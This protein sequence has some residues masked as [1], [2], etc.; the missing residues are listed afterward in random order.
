MDGMIA[1][2]ASRIAALSP[3][4]PDEPPMPPLIGCLREEGL[5]AACAPVE[6]GGQALAHHP[7]DP[8][9]LLRALAAIGGANLSAGRL[10]EGHVNAVKLVALFARGG[11]R[12]RWLGDVGRGAFFG[13][14]GADGPEP[15][16]VA[17]G[18]LHGQKLYASGADVLDHAVISARDRDGAV[19]LFVL[20]TDRLA[21]RLY[22]GEWST[23]GMRATAS[24]RCDLN[25]F[26]L[27]PEDRLGHPGDYHREPHFQGG[28]WRYAAVQLGAMRAILGAAAAQLRRRGHDGAP[29]Q[30]A[31]LRRMTTAC[32]T[33]RLWLARAAGEVE[34]PG[35]PP[36]AA[37][38]SILARLV[39]ADEAANLLAAAD[40]AL[41]A[42]SFD[43]GH[44]VE[45][46]RRDLQLYLRQANPDGLEQAALATILGDPCLAPA[47]HL[48]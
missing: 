31:R 46:R 34:R 10:F 47:W 23:T 19:V 18:R 21:G 6:D 37:A 48:G 44:P 4:G 39:V 7:P 22:P 40:A 36:S 30:L 29:L 26:Q 25:G 12:R 14:W 27:R 2:A 16:R 35:A 3:P 9:V 45:R 1:R 43:T 41:G 24:G 13:V 28:V 42:A 20:P 11:R 32:E 17:D 33:A 5:L 8:G 15:V 38:A